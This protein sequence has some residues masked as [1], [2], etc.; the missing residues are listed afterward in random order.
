MDASLWVDS[1]A[2][3]VD[4][5]ASWQPSAILVPVAL[6]AAALA[7]GPG[8]AVPGIALAAA[9]Q[10]LTLAAGTG[11]VTPH[12][13]CSIDTVDVPLDVRQCTAVPV[14]AAAAGVPDARLI[15]NAIG[16]SPAAGALVTATGGSIQTHACLGQGRVA[17]Q[18]GT[19]PAS[20]TAKEAETATAVVASTAT[21]NLALRVATVAEKTEAFLS[22]P[23]TSPRA[24]GTGCDTPV[25]R[26]LPLPSGLARTSVLAMPAVRAVT[27]PAPFTTS[28][29]F[30][31]AVAFG[32]R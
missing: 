25:T 21:A 9:G 18:T 24:A 23:F 5:P 10:P 32:Q 2:A 13:L 26:T 28:I 19:G 27:R 14:A 3:W 20:L 30:D 12:C 8:T 29:R 17:G 31:A 16:V 7:T 6:V 22:W 1:A 4:A 11:P 15:P